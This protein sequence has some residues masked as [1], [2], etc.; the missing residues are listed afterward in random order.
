MLY[1]TAYTQGEAWD[2]P[3]K[4]TRKMS[5]AVCS[6]NYRCVQLPTETRDPDMQAGGRFLHHVPASGWDVTYAA[7]TLAG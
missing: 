2:I 1:R 6:V 5:G 3:H 7:L 4:K